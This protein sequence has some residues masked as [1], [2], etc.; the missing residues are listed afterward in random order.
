M[1]RVELKKS[2]IALLQKL[3][4]K[5]FNVS[6]WIVSEIY[7]NLVSRTNAINVII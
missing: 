5:F 4:N 6:C 3:Y 1:H 2:H 7:K